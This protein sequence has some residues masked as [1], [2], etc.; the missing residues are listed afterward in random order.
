MKKKINN[1]VMVLVYSRFF[2]YLSA[3][4]ISRNYGIPGKEVPTSSRTGRKV[5]V[6]QSVCHSWESGSRE[7]TE[8]LGGTLLPSG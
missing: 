7:L 6:Y 3:N 2:S 1:D 4:S 8:P 5:V